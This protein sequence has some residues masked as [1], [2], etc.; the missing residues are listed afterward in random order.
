MVTVDTS[1]RPSAGRDE[2]HSTAGRLSSVDVALGVGTM[3]VRGAAFLT[4]TL[5]AVAAPVTRLVLHPPVLPP[6]VHPGRWLEAVARAGFEQRPA[7]LRLLSR[8]LDVVVPAVLT[9][10]LDRVDLTSTVAARVDLDA[11]VATV[12]LDAA[13]ARVDLEAAVARV[14]LDA[15]AARLD[16]DA[17]ARGL[18]LDA[19]LDRLDLTKLVKERVDLN[20][21]V[22]T[23]DVDAVA[24]A[25]D[26]DAVARRLDLDAVIERIDLVGLAEDVMDEIDLP[27]IIRASTGTVASETVRGV[28]MQGIAGD[29]A[30]GRVVNRFLRRRGR[31]ADGGA[32]A[33]AVLPEPFDPD[34]V[35]V[36]EEPG[37]TSSRS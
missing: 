20:A 4:R 15:A 25:L 37:P 7:A 2:I 11:L 18:D 33:A 32:G 9:E 24:G 29:E 1:T 12:D 6:R 23:V 27:E 36:P 3:G 26:V 8:T 5:A 13:V 22:A 14:D 28:R 21:L 10:V 17:V 19:V 31:E 30:V 35:A 34:T 16:L